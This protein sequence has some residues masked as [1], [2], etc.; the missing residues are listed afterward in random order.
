M[1]YYKGDLMR[2][3]TFRR[4]SGLVPRFE[5][6]DWFSAKDGA[7]RDLDSQRTV[8]P[9]ADPDVITIIRVLD[10]PLMNHLRAAWDSIFRP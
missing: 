10:R 2:R 3:I 1:R 8:W 5:D 9:N 6:D 4:S 7:I